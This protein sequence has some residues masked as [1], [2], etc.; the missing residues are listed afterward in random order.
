MATVTY[1][2]TSYGEPLADVDVS[3]LTRKEAHDLRL[4]LTH[5]LVRDDLDMTE[6]V[7]AFYKK[8]IEEIKAFLV[9]D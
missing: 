9:T 2:E 7:E 3:S 8:K 1:T 6:E 5:E 4:E